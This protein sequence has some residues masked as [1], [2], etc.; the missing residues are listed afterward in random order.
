MSQYKLKVLVTGAGGQLGQELIRIEHDEVEFIGLE[1]LQLD[2][3][4]LNKCRTVFE[5]HRPNVVIHAGAYTAVDQAEADADQAFKV[6]ALGTRNIAVAARE[7][8]AKV[9]YI[10]TDYVFDGQGNTPYN[11]YD[12]TNPRTVYG[13]SKLAGEKLL[14]TLSPNYFIV[15][16]SWV[17]G[18]YGNNFVKTML[19]LAEEGKSIQ[20]VNDQVGSPTSTL[21]L[22]VFLIQLIKTDFYGI[23]HATNSGRCSWYD[24]AAAIFKHLNLDVNLKACTSEQFTRPAPRPS[25][26]VMDHSA[27]RQ[28]GFEE[29]P[30]WLIALKRFLSSTIASS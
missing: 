26:S 29:L 22:S 3:T 21:D 18:Q 4:D 24:F 9:C 7:I 5:H 2:F 23:Y 10:S 30:D 20:V 13:K 19:K 27:I 8:N 6:N 25:F 15:R 28:N 16:T 12:V 14:Q 17:Y 11:E 1:R